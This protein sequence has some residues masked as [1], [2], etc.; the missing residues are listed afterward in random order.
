MEFKFSD[1]FDVSEYE[2]EEM[3]EKIKKEYYSIPQAI[4]EWAEGLSDDLFYLVGYI[5]DDLAKEIE[6][7]L[8]NT[9]KWENE[10]KAII[11]NKLFDSILFYAQEYPNEKEEFF[12]TLIETLKDTIDSVKDELESEE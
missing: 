3:C 9:Q 8:K 7:R 2:I 10:C 5:E 1:N 4:S 11:D 6:K 12:N